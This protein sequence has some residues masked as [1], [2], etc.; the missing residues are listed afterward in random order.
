MTQTVTTTTTTSC[1]RNN[2][3]CGIGY[4]IRKHHSSNNSNSKCG[5]NSYKTNEV[6]PPSSDTVFQNITSLYQFIVWYDYFVFR[7]IR[8][9]FS[10]SI[11]ASINIRVNELREL[12]SFLNLVDSNALDHTISD[13]KKYNEKTDKAGQINPKQFRNGTLKGESKFIVNKI[14]V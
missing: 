10:F 2:S 7:F 3:D 13:V 1:N 5:S 14:A 8:F 6:T 4:K 9:F 11:E 12:K